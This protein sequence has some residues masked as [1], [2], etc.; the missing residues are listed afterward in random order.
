[1]KNILFINAWLFLPF[2]VFAQRDSI[3]EGYGASQNI[4]VIQTR[5]AHYPKGDV[6]LYTLFYHG[7]HYS[8]E[9][10]ANKLRGEVKVSFMVE[11]DS[12]IT[13]I[14][15]LKDAISE[16]IKLCSSKYFLI[17]VLPYLYICDCSIEYCFSS[18]RALPYYFYYISR[19]YI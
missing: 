3:P 6:V 11:T 16:S 5:E 17:R 7:I 4:E 15:L 8:E 14:K 10:L 18:S 19:F 13:E 12:T 1:M 9:A 2:I